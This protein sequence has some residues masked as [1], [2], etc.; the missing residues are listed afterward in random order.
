MRK[1][2]E[3]AFESEIQ[4][5][6]VIISEKWKRLYTVLGQVP[7]TNERHT[8]SLVISCNGEIFIHNIP[9]GRSPKFT[10]GAGGGTYTVL[11]DQ[12]ETR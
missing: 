8:R 6:D 1:I 7:V 5:G 12:H 4:V 9:R 10:F 2:G 3:L 11:G